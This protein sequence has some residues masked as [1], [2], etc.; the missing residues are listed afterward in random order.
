[1]VCL[2]VMMEFLLVKKMPDGDVSLPDGLVY[3]ELDGQPAVGVP[4]GLVC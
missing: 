4:V 1:M 3:E 2:L